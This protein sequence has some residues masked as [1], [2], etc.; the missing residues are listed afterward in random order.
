MN[1]TASQARWPARRK[2]TIFGAGSWG[3]ALSVLLTANGHQVTLWARRPEVAAHIRR[4]RHNPTY[5]TDVKLP[6][7][8]YVTSALKEAAPERD[9]WIVATPAQA[10]RALAEQLR[11]W[12]RAELIVVSV[13]KGLEIATLKTTT[14][15]LAEVLPEVPRERIGVLYGPSHAEEVA[16]GMPTTVVAAAPSCAVAE[17]IQAL[18]MAPTFRV[19]VNPDLIGVEIAGSVKNVMALAAGMSD[20][21]GF[22]DNAKA[23]LIT[24]GIAEIQRLGVR[25]GADPATFAGLAG[26]GDLV[27]TCMSRHSR[28]R[29]VG[30]Q[31]GRGR[32]LE[33]VQR[34]MQMVAEGVPTTAAVYRLARQLGVEMPITEAVYQILFE[35]KKPAEAVRELM[36][37][38]A[39]YEDWLPQAAMLEPPNGLVAS[40]SASCR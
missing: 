11:P 10:V 7:A 21:V 22:G 8:I 31:I 23:A 3:T 13:A 35:G 37:R 30:E 33:E 17:E 25:L 28:N 6:E 9:V 39:K 32:T 27:V 14:Q 18:F 29:Y 19:Y 4:T 40:K 38:E 12:A 26:I 15:V 5:L 36:T 1:A 34:E 20:G 2:L 16:A 24:R